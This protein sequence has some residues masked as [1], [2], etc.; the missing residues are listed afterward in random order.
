MS[1]KTSGQPAPKD[2]TYWKILRGALELDFK[3]GHQRWTISELSRV[4]G[5]TRSLI[6]YYFGK[7]RESLLTE[8]VRL[9]GEELFGLS[10][11]RLKLW[12]AGRGEE[13][14]RASRRMALEQPFLLGF[15]FSNRFR[16]SAVGREI[17][18]LEKKHLARL[19]RLSPKPPEQLRQQM[20]SIFG[21]VLCPHSIM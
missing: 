15:Y 3:K 7:S 6:Y 21:E 16:P 8:A 2:E 18:E 13:S 11:E 17:R 10:T 12:E 14:I 20:Y 9:I 5:V 19:R 1:L 4:S